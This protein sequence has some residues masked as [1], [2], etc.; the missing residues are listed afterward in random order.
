MPQRHEGMSGM[1]R[2]DSGAA[3]GEVLR[4]L[5]MSPYPFGV[6]FFVG[7]GVPAGPRVNTFIECGCCGAFHRTDF[8]G[9]CREDSERYPELPDD[10]IEVFDVED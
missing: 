2:A 8:Y 9:D 3:V 5:P 1:Q 7:A 6:G 10:G 4:G